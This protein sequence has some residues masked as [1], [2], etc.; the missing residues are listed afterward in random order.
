MTL[1]R[2]A[3]T[4]T[5][6]HA[7]MALTMVLGAHVIDEA[8]TDFLSVYNPLVLSARTRLG[9]FPMPTFTFATWL[10]GLAALVAVL[11]VLSL[12]AYRGAAP[13]RV[14]AYPYGVIMLLNGLGHL[15]ASVY[16]GRWMPGTTTA[17]LLLIAS[18]WLLWTAAR[19]HT[20]A[21]HTQRAAEI[22]L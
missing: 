14:L 4:R 7:W 9:W 16:F 8:L 21:P 12:F 22:D 20:Y 11:L 15:T 3:D 5:F 10:T 6:G 17:P 2:Y 13:L 1:R 19:N 18:S